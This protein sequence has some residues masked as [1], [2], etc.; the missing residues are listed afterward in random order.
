MI[1]NFGKVLTAM[2]FIQIGFLMLNF[3]GIFPERVVPQFQWIYDSYN[4]TINAINAVKTADVGA[5]L[6]NPGAA[7]WPIIMA[8]KLAIILVISA[9]LVAGETLNILLGGIGGLGLASV[10]TIIFY[11]SFIVWV[12]RVIR[13]SDV[14]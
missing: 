13:G 9:P 3:S 5:L 10:F 7:V 8:L 14:D 11:L 12:I 4:D 1:I 2:I 6:V